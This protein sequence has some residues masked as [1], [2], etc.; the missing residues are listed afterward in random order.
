MRTTDPDQT[1]ASGRD[2]GQQLFNRK[3]FEQCH[4]TLRPGDEFTAD[5]ERELMRAERF[6]IPMVLMLLDAVDTT[7][8]Q[9]FSPHG[10]EVL[11][12]TIIHSNS[13]RMTDIIGW[14]RDRR[15][16]H[17]GLL[18]FNATPASA[19]LVLDKIQVCF[20][21]A[22]DPAGNNG[23][24]RPQLACE[25]YAYP[26]EGERYPRAANQA[27]P[28]SHPKDRYEIM[29]VDLLMQQPLPKW[30][31]ALDIVGALLAI[32]IFSPILFIVC[33]IVKLT[34]R[35]PVLFRQVRVGLGGRV[36]DCLKFRT[37]RL[38]YDTSTHQQHM[39]ELI[40]NGEDQPMRKLD[41]QNAQI[42]AIGR[43][44]RPTH[45]DELP[46]LFNVLGGSMS[47]VGPRPCIPYE[48]ERYSLWCRRRFDILPGITGL[49]QVRGKNK[50]SFAR[51]MRFDIE[52]VRH[53]SL[54][55]DLKVLILTI[56]TIIRDAFEAI[57]P[58]RNT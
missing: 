31:R 42:T 30:K 8:P 23:H 45:M 35:G 17:I 28:P 38:G 10:L 16:T 25:I 56:P 33:A 53:Y 14:Y 20:E 15:G 2:F 12:E 3:R 43:L 32:L 1:P 19:N 37:M 46:Q 51:M 36:F 22:L 40:H 24:G 9:E 49:W 52:Y 34:S 41:N 4:P 11:A 5:V 39:A 55:L 26:L 54:W 13:T 27:P 48:A 6:N 44:L 7:A 47:L 58:Q 50:V 57:G 18:L 21:Q 29:S